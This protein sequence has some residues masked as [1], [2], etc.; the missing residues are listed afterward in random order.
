M[1]HVD[2][3]HN[4]HKLLVALISRGDQCVIDD[5][6]EDDDDDNEDDQIVEREDWIAIVVQSKATLRV[7]E[8][9]LDWEIEDSR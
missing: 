6:D 1:Y 5:D 9:D 7:T 3:R 2:S 4:S 8:E